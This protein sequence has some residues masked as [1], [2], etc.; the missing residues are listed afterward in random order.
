MVAWPESP[1]PSMIIGTFA[2]TKGR[3]LHRRATVDRE[4]E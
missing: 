1:M 4:T 3:Q 2:A